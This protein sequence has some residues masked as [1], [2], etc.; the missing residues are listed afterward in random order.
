M[1]VRYS[2]KRDGTHIMVAALVMHVRVSVT[3]FVAMAVIMVALAVV[4][5]M[6]KSRIAQHHSAKLERRQ[7]SGTHSSV[8]LGMSYITDS[9]KP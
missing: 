2:K 1:A 9:Q 7:H 5:I 3:V 6:L 4:V 8:T